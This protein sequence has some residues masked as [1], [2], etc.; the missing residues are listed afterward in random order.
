[1]RDWMQE[2]V[3]LNIQ[4]YEMVSRVDG[5]KLPTF[6]RIVRVQQPRK[7]GIK[8]QKTWILNLGNVFRVQHLGRALSVIVPRF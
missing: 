3:L 4:A 8:S 7:H 5:K 1:M 6:R 2:D